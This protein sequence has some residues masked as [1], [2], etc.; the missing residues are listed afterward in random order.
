M[1]HL[2]YPS[3]YIAFSTNFAWSFG[4]FSKSTFIQDAIESMRAKTGSNLSSD[5]QAPSSYADRTLSP[6]NLYAIEGENPQTIDLGSFVG[7]TTAQ[8][9]SPAQSTVAPATITST[10]ETLDPGIPVYVNQMGVATGNAFMSLFIT[11]LF[12]LA[13]FV[14]LV[15]AVILALRAFK[16]YR[17]SAWADKYLREIRP[18]LLSNGLRLVRQVCYNYVRLTN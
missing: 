1:L 13:A 8:A 17:E 15:V 14:L 3:T 4:L 7:G 11:M 2:N 12:F 10:S 18:I 16:K 6:Y 5:S 9:A